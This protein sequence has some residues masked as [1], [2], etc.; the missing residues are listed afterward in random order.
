MRD[1][2]TVLPDVVLREL[3]HQVNAYSDF[4]D[5]VDALDRFVDRAWDVRRAASAKTIDPVNSLFVTLSNWTDD[6]RHMLT[7]PSPLELPSLFQ[8]FDELRT[9][10]LGPHTAERL[11]VVCSWI[12]SYV[13]RNQGASG[14]APSD[15]WVVR[16]LSGGSPFRRGGDSSPLPGTP[17]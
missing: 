13:D 11:K 4:L 15:G 10:S 8:S 3:V 2:V 9:P 16:L 12:D 17:T 14:E 7:T 6:F 1:F 5:Q